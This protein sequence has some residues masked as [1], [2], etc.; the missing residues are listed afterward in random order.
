[1]KLN[2]RQ[3]IVSTSTTSNFLSYNQTS[4]SVDIVSTS[5][6]GNEAPITITAAFLDDDY[7]YEQNGELVSAWG[8]FSWNS[9]WG[10]EPGTVTWYLYWDI[11][12]FTGAVTR[13]YT[14]APIIASTGAPTS[15]L[16]DQ[17]WFDLA[18]N[19][20]MVWNGTQWSIV[21][22]VFAGY[23]GSTSNIVTPYPT[24]SQVG[25]GNLSVDID[26]GY[27][28]YGANLQ[29]IRTTLG[30][31]LTTATN[32]LTNPSGSFTSPVQL[33]TLSTSL[34]AMESI[35]AFS[36]IYTDGNGNAGLAS[37]TDVTKTAIGIATT[38]ANPGT[39]VSVVY[40][41][42]VYNSLWNWNVASGK[43]LYAGTAGALVQGA[44]G[45]AGT[46]IGS[47]LNSN[48]IIISLGVVGPQGATGPASTV[49]GPT[50][51]SVTGPAGPTGAASTVTGPTGAIGATGASV[52]GPTGSTGPTGAASTVTGPT[53]AVG[54]TG[55][56]V[57]GP[58]GA[59][60][61]VTGP[62]G[63]TGPS[64]TGPTG[65]AST[66]TG[67]T[68]AT[69]A[70]GPSITGPTGAASTVTGPTGPSVTG[71]T[72]AVGATGPT[73]AASTAST[74]PNVGDASTTIS[75]ATKVTVIFNS[76]LTANRTVTLSA[77]GNTDGNTV[78]ITRTAAATGSATL[79]INDTTNTV[80]A[81]GQWCEVT[82][83]GSTS[84]WIETSS[85][86]LL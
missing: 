2:F 45:A 62:T 38:N 32:I 27:I 10:T 71:P 52:T 50:G 3:G 68:G 4:S 86:S 7:L 17:H 12:Q 74:L 16:I 5:N 36:A 33:E 60:S 28:L 70:T 29:A 79:T 51:P 53:G 39:A 31:F 24:G 77:S 83:W 49:T 11:N 30:R 69:G 14:H 13:G 22:R 25:L 56:S 40:Y 66:V 26:A 8:P 37:A 85:G 59:A 41:G 72:G 84:T 57:T 35:P 42:A 43:N 47:I 23:F 15:P 76:P 58:T 55:P 65:A 61:T 63:A 48:T 18:T 34:I 9:A 6:A 82:Y 73:G 75:A 64:V 1:M 46:K 54:A 44:P 80:L 19:Q 21:I 67:P 78:K 20:M 81:A